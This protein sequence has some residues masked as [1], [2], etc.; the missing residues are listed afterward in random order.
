MIK[1]KIIFFFLITVFLNAFPQGSLPPGMYTSTNKKAIKFY[2]EGKK[3]Y[4]V[5]KDKE[6]EELLTK[7]LKEDDNFVEA[8]S[9]LAFLLMGYNR[10][11]EA[12][13]SAAMRFTDRER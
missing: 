10:S 6:A 2:E 8:H 12:I 4:E 9:A 11:A 13:R 3:Y 7:A 5:R 1:H